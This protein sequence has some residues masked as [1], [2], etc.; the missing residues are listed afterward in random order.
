MHLALCFVCISIKNDESWYY[1]GYSRR[2]FDSHKENNAE[3]I[4]LK[5]IRTIKTES[6]K[7]TKVLIY[8]S[9][10]GS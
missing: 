7:E 3:D 4:V 1:F 5:F 8:Q 10:S 9:S 6:R 2:A